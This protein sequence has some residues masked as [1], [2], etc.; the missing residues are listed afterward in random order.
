MTNLLMKYQNGIFF[1][2]DARS[3]IHTHIHTHGQ[4]QSNMPLQLF[5]IW[6]NKHGTRVDYGKCNWVRDNYRLENREYYVR[7]F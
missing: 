1:V 3:Y 4:A 2:A 5:Q 6:G 7:V